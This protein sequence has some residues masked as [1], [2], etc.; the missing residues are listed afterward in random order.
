LADC[1]LRDLLDPANEPM[2]PTVAVSGHGD[3]LDYDIAPMPK[4]ICLTGDFTFK[5]SKP[6]FAQ[7]AE[8]IRRLCAKRPEGLGLQPQQVFVCPGNHDLDYEAHEAELRWGEYASF[9][10]KIYPDKFEAKEP[11]HFGGSARVR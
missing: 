10:N 3:H 1:L 6:E 2:R 11:A 5:A 9:L 7:A 4:V 8:L